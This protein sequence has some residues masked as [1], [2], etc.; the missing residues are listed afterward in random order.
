MQVKHLFKHTGGQNLVYPDF[1]VLYLSVVVVDSNSCINLIWI[2]YIFS[3]YQSYDL[4]SYIL[5][6][7]A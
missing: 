5:I 2:S 1:I 6:L 7:L 3:N 4:C